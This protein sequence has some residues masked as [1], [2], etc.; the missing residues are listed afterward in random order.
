[1]IAHTCRSW[2]DVDPQ[3]NTLRCHQSEEK[4]SSTPTR[5]HL[6]DS[7]GMCF[8][9]SYHPLINV[10]QRGY[11]QSPSR[12][13]S[14]NGS[15]RAKS[16]SVLQTSSASTWRTRYRLNLDNLVPISDV[17]AL[18]A[19]IGAP[20]SQRERL[21]IPIIQDCFTGAAISDTATI[22]AHLDETYPSR[23]LCSYP[24]RTLLR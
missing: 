2:M 17:K 3:E 22:V 18:T 1:M 10:I 20:T 24:A 6:V 11:G 14:Q 16:S 19:R 5:R 15:A 9:A 12:S 4:T 13:L 23:N 21:S 8:T 7:L